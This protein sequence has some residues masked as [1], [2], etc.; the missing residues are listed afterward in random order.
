MAWS[1][2]RSG[3]GQCRWCERFMCQRRYLRLMTRGLARGR[4]CGRSRATSSRMAWHLNEG[5]ARRRGEG[6]APQA[7]L[8]ASRCSLNEGH[9]RRRGEGLADFGSFDRG[10]YDQLRAVLGGTESGGYSIVKERRKLL[11]RVR[12][13]CRLIG[14]RSPAGPSK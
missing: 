1:G 8:R 4:R 2:S 5:R 10:K 11:V 7:C 3:W 12:G 14:D 9:A 6:H 13:R